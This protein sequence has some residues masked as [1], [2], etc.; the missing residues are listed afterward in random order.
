M[1]VCVEV[2]DGSRL[3]K[4]QG[5][6]SEAEPWSGE[7]EECK[8]QSTAEPFVLGGGVGGVK[9]TRIKGN[10]ANVPFSVLDDERFSSQEDKNSMLLQRER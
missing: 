1:F 6:V 9:M 10:K 4:Q 8:A 3:K 7:V 5:R 2:V